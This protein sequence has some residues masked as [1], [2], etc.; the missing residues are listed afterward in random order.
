MCCMFVTF[1]EFGPGPIVWVYM[2][3]IMNDKGVSI[4][5]VINLTLTLVIGIVSP[6]MINSVGGW[7]FIIFGA[8]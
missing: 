3:E 4:G 7:A 1:F 2:S 6:I 5:T 8:C